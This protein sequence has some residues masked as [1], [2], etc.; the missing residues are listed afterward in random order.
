MGNIVRHQTNIV[1]ATSREG[2]TELASIE[3]SNR[4]VVGTVRYEF[5]T[6]RF[7]DSR[8]MN[9]KDAR[10]AFDVAIGRAEK[11]AVRPC[12]E[13][14]SHSAGIQILAPLGVNEAECFIEAAIGVRKP[15]DIAKVMRGKEL[16]RAFLGR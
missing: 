3:P 14:S 4:R 12:D 16:F 6:E 11:I 1:Q 10:H 15:G 13:H 5:M 7:A 9:Q 2:F 8:V